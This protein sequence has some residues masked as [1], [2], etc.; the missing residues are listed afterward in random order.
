MS[1][2]FG[3]IDQIIRSLAIVKKDI[4]I[5]YSKGPV[6]MMGVLWPAAMFISFAFGRGMA[7]ESLMPGLIG[8]SVFFTCS[9]ITPVAFPWETSA[10]TLERLVSSPVA[11][12]T[13]LF[14]DM[15][16]SALVGVVISIVPIIIA[17]AFGVTFT[18]PLALVLAII[19]GSVCFA[20]M[21]LL[22]SVAPVSGPQYAQMISTLI[23]FPLLFISGVF[24]P[25]SN[26]PE[27]ARAISFVS[28]LTY[29]TDIARYATGHDSYL[30]ILVD[31]GAIIVFTVV[32]WIVAVKLHNRTLPL[33]V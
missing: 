13:I 23:K 4:K 10:R 16:A 7:I 8:V 24:V 9:A 28:P 2:S 11:I 17:I 1:N 32:L 14:G 21:A 29:F 12:W 3:L 26:L 22:F 33:R 19:T 31:F 25:L 6:V 30:P 27:V 18:S 20:T 15:L 5:Y